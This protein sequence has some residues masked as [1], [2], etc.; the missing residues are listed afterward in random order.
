[1][2]FKRYVVEKIK[3]SVIIPVYNMGQYLEQC[4]TNILEQTLKEIE[5]ICIN[6]GSTDNSLDILNRYKEKNSNIKV[7]SQKNQ[8]SGLAR[9]LGINIANGEFVA[10]VD[11]DDYYAEN[12]VLEYLYNCAKRENV[13]ICGGGLIREQEGQ[14]FKSK[15]KSE[16]FIKDGII[17]YKDFQQ[18]CG[19]TGFIFSKVLLKEN[20]IYF[21]NYRRFQDIPFVVK[22]MIYA[23]VFYVVSKTVYVYRS[24]DKLIAYKNED[25]VN[26]IAKGIDDVLVMSKEAGYE[27]LHADIV[28]KMLEG[29]IEW[30][31]KSIYNGNKLMANLIQKIWDDIDEE[32]LVK[33]GR[34]TSKPELKNEQEIN[35]YFEEIKYKKE[36]F[37]KK[38]ECFKHI[39]I[40]GAGMMGRRLFEYLMENDY[41]GMIDFAVSIPNPSGFACGKSIHSIT[42]FLPD[43][44]NVLI[45]IAVKGDDCY[46]M[47]NKAQKL[48]Y[49]NVEIV[50][51]KDI[52]LF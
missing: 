39:I 28:Q 19:Y 2:V 44:D 3:V 16:N 5:V 49:R 11:A 31:Y 41:K 8:G 17:K 24:V 37:W 13:S 35:N 40:Y 14:L 26:G 33:D 42:K 47:L 6:D 34:M 21:P 1:M 23:D 9:N 25:I 50:F 12:D 4:L 20:L 43:K 7:I 15:E 30:F 46:T 45:L 36:E 32:L 38:I 52:M 10:F 29:Y 27:I 22:A 18:V 51:Y 48:G